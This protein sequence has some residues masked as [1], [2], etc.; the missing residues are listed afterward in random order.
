MNSHRR[1]YSVHLFGISARKPNSS[2]SISRPGFF[3]KMVTD[4]PPTHVSSAKAEVFLFV[5]CCCFVLK[6]N[7][8][9]KIKTIWI[10]L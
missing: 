8:Q 6:F 2:A 7:L 5:L 9:G 3:T 1:G 10:K 4:P